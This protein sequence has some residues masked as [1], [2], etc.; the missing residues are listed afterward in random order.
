MIVK[1]KKPITPMVEVYTSK[2]KD[3]A[4]SSNKI[5]NSVERRRTPGRIVKQ[6]VFK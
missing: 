6:N 5:D 2:V 4:P 1:Q 3:K